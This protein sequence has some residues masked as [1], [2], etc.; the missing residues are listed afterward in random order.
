MRN[1]NFTEI[2]CPNKNTYSSPQAFSAEAVKRVPLLYSLPD[3]IRI[4]KSRRMTWVGHVVCIGR[5]VY[6]V[7]GGEAGRKEIARKT[8]I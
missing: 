3:I 1:V 7:L 5:N 6:G 2:F 4:I 8:K